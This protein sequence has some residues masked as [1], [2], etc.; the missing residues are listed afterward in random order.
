MHYSLCH[1]FCRRELTTRVHSLED[2]V[3]SIY[4]DQQLTVMAGSAEQWVGRVG[5]TGGGQYQVN[6]PHILGCWS[7]LEMGARTSS[8]SPCWPGNGDRRMLWATFV[9]LR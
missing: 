5:D 2:S 7:M 9:S 1:V 4:L 3:T 6:I 8:P